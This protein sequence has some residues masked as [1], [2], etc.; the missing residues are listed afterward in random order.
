MISSRPPLYS[1]VVCHWHLVRRFRRDNRFVLSD[2]RVIL[3]RISPD[4]NSEWPRI[5]HL[6]VVL[7]AGYRNACWLFFHVIMLGL[8]FVPMFTDDLQRPGGSC[9]T[10]SVIASLSRDHVL[11]VTPFIANVFVL[12][13]DYDWWKCDDAITC[14]MVSLWV[15]D[16]TFH[17]EIFRSVAFKGGV[18]GNGWTIK[19]DALPISSI[20]RSFFTTQA[21]VFSEKMRHWILYKT[22]WKETLP[23]H[24]WERK[25]GQYYHA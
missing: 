21:S 12:E 9:G 24:H 19:N 16:R 11:S 17:I 8:F 10:P 3:L 2:Q 5:T 20:F 13:S 4:R 22:L 15:D 18:F 6:R 25:S 14:C 23:M 7:R 1:A